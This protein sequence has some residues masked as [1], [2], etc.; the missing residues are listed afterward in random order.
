M[1]KVW[2]P[3]MY[4]RLISVKMKRNPPQALLH[5]PPSMTKLEVKE[6]LTKIYGVNVLDV[7]TANFLGKWKRLYAKR[8]IISYKRRNFKAAFVDFEKPS[9]AK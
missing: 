9:E 6:Y 2:F 4:M 7:A 1:V 3:N 5:V 8:S